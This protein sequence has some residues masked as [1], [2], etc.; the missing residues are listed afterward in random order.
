MLVL[1][2]AVLSPGGAA[3]SRAVLILGHL[4]SQGL[5]GEDLT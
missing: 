3:H 4:T 2:L 5:L 1:C